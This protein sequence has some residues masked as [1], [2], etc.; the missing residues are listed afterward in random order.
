M[1]TVVWRRVNEFGNEEVVLG[2]VIDD[3]LEL[4]VL[5]GERWG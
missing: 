3:S 1:M 4:D 5:D 2:G